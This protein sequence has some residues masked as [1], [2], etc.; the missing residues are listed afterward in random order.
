MQ[1]TKNNQ[2]NLNNKAGRFEPTRYQDLLQRFKQTV[3][4]GQVQKD[5]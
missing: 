1:K 3:I 5:Q 2:G 4:L